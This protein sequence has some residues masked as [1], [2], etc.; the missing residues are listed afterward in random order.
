M[1]DIDKLVEKYF[2][3][4]N[5]KLSFNTLLEMIEEQMDNLSLIFEDAPPPIKL[6]ADTETK[7][8]ERIIRFPKIKITERW[9]QKNNEDRAIFETLMGKIKGNTVQQ[10]LESVA[11]FVSH[12][13]GL[14]VS[15]I[16]S[17]LMFLEIFSNIL[18][19][20][21]PSVAGFLFEAFL[22]GLFEGV[23]I[24]DPEKGSLPI[25]DVELFVQRGFGETEEITPYSL[26]VLSPTTDLKGSFK[27]LVDFFNKEGNISV[28]YLAVMKLGGT[29]DPAA[30]L[31]FFE[32]DI[33]RKTFFDWIGHEKI[34]K[35]RKVETVK[36]VPADYLNTETNRIQFGGLDINKHKIVDGNFKLSIGPTREPYNIS[37]DGKRLMANEYYDV[38]GEYEITIYTGEEEWE[39]T[40]E[41]KGEYGKLFGDIQFNFE[42]PAEDLFQKLMLTP[43][44]KNNEQW[45]VSP[46]Y[47]RKF[48]REIAELK[49]SRETLRRTAEAYASNLGESLIDL[50]NAIALLSINV[51][52]YFLASDKGAGMSAKQNAET[53]RDESRKLISDERP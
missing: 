1:Q 49:L 26:K 44:Y 51:N 42:D 13:E 43:G 45:H 16:L 14:D 22:A 20:F 6:D 38:N 32:F 36:F 24:A 23:Q 2:K 40:G 29:D 19:E 21:N 53:V 31:K 30:R 41:R 7:P 25:E 34:K 50:Y 12:Q 3:P 15:E 9:G 17:H 46:S 48:S 35:V 10:K 47:Y 5:G 28:T 4:S 37:A 39:K 11:S 18:E 33:T 27:N 52:K 8:D